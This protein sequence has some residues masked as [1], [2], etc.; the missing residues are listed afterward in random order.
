MV[1]NAESSW[2]G[3]STVLCLQPSANTTYTISAGHENLLDQQDKLK[4]KEDKTCQPEHA[5][6]SSE[7]T[8]RV[9]MGRL[10]KVALYKYLTS[11][12]PPQTDACRS[13]KT[14]KQKASHT[15]H[16]KNCHRVNRR[17]AS[18]VP[19]LRCGAGFS[20]WSVAGEGEAG[21]I[22][23]RYR[24]LRQ[25]T[26]PLGRRTRYMWCWPRER[27][28]ATLSHSFHCRSWTQTV[29]PR[30]RGSRWLLRRVYRRMVVSRRSAAR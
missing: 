11:P 28:V 10:F 5:C 8:A 13:A 15:K 14:M 23:R 3:R 12:L 22:W 18:R 30:F 20:L 21:G 16:Y 19:V 2:W 25:R 6:I 7:Y 27:T 17:R 1:I 24:R 4:K 26:R 9:A 29:E